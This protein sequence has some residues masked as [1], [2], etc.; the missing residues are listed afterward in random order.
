M[1]VH[2]TLGTR[3][4]PADVVAAWQASGAETGPL[5]YPTSSA[6]EV[7][8][9]QAVTF[10]HGAV[11]AEDG[12]GTGHVLTGAVLDRYLEADGPAG[13][14]GL[15][16]S[17]A[18]PLAG[19]GSYAHFE[20]G[21]IYSSPATGARVLT[22]AIRGRWAAAG[23]ENSPLGYPTSDVAEAPGGGEYA[24]F[25]QGTVTWSSATGARVLTGPVRDA[26]LASGGVSGEL[27][28]ATS[29]VTALAGGG[30]F[31]HF[32]HGSVYYSPATGARVLTGAVRDRWAALGWENSALGYPTSD[33]TPLAGG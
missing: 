18:A 22:G 27:G 14:L 32:Q 15:P 19:G 8:G 3:V 31:A 10:E 20:H 26:W 6:S 7:P 12:V 25:Q 29:D 23:W 30:A 28:L 9:G 16:A 5:G 2:P 17:S 11:Y 33:V 4:L 1:Y 13:E 21:S 24:H